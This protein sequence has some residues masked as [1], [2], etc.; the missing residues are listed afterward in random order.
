MTPEDRVRQYLREELGVAS[1]QSLDDDVMLIE[2]GIIDSL[3]IFQMVQFLESELGVVVEDDE[4]LLENFQ[5]IGHIGGFVRAKLGE[6]N[7]VGG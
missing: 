1:S 4:L 3:G 5:T 6:P 2:Q 7:R